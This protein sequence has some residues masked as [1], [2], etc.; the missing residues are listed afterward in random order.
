MIFTDT[1]RVA[2]VLL[3]M[4]LLSGCSGQGG[5]DAGDSQAIKVQA[6]ADPTLGK[7]IDIPQGWSAD[8]AKGGTL[9][10]CPDIEG[11]WQANVF[12]E[13]RTDPEAR[14]LEQAVDSLIENAPKRHQGFQLVDK[15]LFQNGNHPYATVTYTKQ[16]KATGLSLTN[17]EMVIKDAG[18]KYVFVLSSSASSVAKKYRPYFEVIQKSIQ[19]SL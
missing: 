6:Y 10:V 8:R 2:T 19:S 17:S 14:P 15:V 13:V 3:A 12:V 11:N 9:I 4:T 7:T 16:E 18:N 5:S 1:A